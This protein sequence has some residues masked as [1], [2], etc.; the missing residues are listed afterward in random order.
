M[1]A[2]TPAVV[3]TWLA[4]LARH[5]GKSECVEMALS[6]YLFISTVMDDDPNYYNSDPR[7]LVTSSDPVSFT[8]GTGSEILSSIFHSCES[9]IHELIIVTCFCK[10]LSY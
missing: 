8:L 3:Q 4:E 5:Q 2:P 7:T 10:S 1:A 6:S 9:T